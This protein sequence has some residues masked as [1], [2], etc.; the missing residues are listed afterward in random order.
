MNI[1]FFKSMDDNVMPLSDVERQLSDSLTALDDLKLTLEQQGMIWQQEY[2]KVRIALEEAYKREKWLL[3]KNA[4]LIRKLTDLASLPENNLLLNQLKM[5]EK[6]VDT[7]LR[8]AQMFHQ[9]IVK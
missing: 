9:V 5:I 1:N 3:E 7:L 6:Q 2:E 4:Q 8:E